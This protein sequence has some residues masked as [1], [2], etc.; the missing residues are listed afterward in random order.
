MCMK[1]YSV[2]EKETEE[3]T[4]IPAS[5]AQRII[6]AYAALVILAYKLC[7]RDLCLQPAHP[8]GTIEGCWL[9]FETTDAGERLDACHLVM[10]D[11]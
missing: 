8:S 9:K 11:K 6:R 10:A 1:L 2:R 4:E 3:E 7:Y 5:L